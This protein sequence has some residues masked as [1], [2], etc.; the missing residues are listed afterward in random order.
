VVEEIEEALYRALD[1]NDVA[2]VKTHE[3]VAYL[4]SRG[5]VDVGIGVRYIADKYSLEFKPITSERYDIVARRAHA[6]RVLFG[7]EDWGPSLRCGNMKDSF[8]KDTLLYG[9]I[10]RIS[11]FYFNYLLIREKYISITFFT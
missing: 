10:Y 2:R 9:G 3:A 1:E 5:V 4:V 8:V 6:P 11:S 7:R